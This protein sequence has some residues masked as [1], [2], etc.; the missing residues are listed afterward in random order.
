MARAV[1]PVARRCA[2]ALF[3]IYSRKIQPRHCQRAYCHKSGEKHGKFLFFRN[4]FNY[5]RFLFV[6]IETL[7]AT[8]AFGTAWIQAI[9][10]RFMAGAIFIM[11][12][13][14]ILAYAL[15]LYWQYSGNIHH[16]RCQTAYYNQP[17][18]KEY[19]FLFPGKF[20]HDPFLFRYQF[21]RPMVFI[22]PIICLIAIYVLRRM[23]HDFLHEKFMDKLPVFCAGC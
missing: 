17:C 5:H 11:A 19:Y 8:S 22:A 6:C 20:F 14:P 15:R 12:T 16:P 9:V 13:L 3:W 10:I 7:L 21:V 4:S 2:F 1:E 23:P 18:D